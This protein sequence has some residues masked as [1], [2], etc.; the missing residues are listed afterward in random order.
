VLLLAPQAAADDSVSETSSSVQFSPP[1]PFSCTHGEERE[2]ELERGSINEL[3]AAITPHRGKKRL[4]PA[5]AAAR[6]WGFNKKAVGAAVHQDEAARVLP[7]GR[8]GRGGA[9]ARAGAG[10][11][12][13]GAGDGAGPGAAARQ[14]PPVLA[15]GP[16][17]LPLLPRRPGSY[18]GNQTSA[19]FLCEQLN[20]CSMGFLCDSPAREEKRRDL[21]LCVLNKR[22]RERER[23]ACFLV[24]FNPVTSATVQSCDRSE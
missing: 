7:H 20:L 2:R 4:P 11:G 14:G 13:V 23:E 9:A 18:Q 17:R 8:T 15:P 16:R 5:G 19:P 24:T 21:N 22:E 12:G 10:A 1:L 6:E 3:A